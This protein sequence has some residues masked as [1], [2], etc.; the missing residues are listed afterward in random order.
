MHHGT[1][2]AVVLAGGGTARGW[3]AMSSHPRSEA[4]MSEYVAVQR[5]GLCATSA[6]GTVL[7]VRRIGRWWHCALIVLVIGC[8]TASSNDNAAPED[9]ASVRA[10]SAGLSARANGEPQTRLISGTYFGASEDGRAWLVFIDAEAAWGALYS[11]P[12]PAELC[13]LTVDAGGRVTLRSA[14]AFRDVRYVFDGVLT[15]GGMS[16][17]VIVTGGRP[18]R[19]PAPADVELRH[20]GGLFPPEGGAE[21][22]T[23]YYSNVR[24]GAEGDLGGYELVLVNRSAGPVGALTFYE[25]VPTLPR[26]V[27]SARIS[28]DTLV[29]STIMSGTEDR[30]TALLYG[31]SVVLRSQTLAIGVQTLQNRGPLE[32]LARTTWESCPQ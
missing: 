17:R 31:D 20:V 11:P 22:V 9:R 32:T 13:E 29:F 4:N 1:S 27:R 26:A 15:L 5:R 30:F 2:V 7:D 8:R 10:D 24:F 18:G 25:G 21:R 23:G 28:G 6:A 19:S 14:I 12:R 16:G 3:S